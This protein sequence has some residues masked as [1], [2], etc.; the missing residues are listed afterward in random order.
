MLLWY[1]MAA[2]DFQHLYCVCPSVLQANDVWASSSQFSASSG[3]RGMETG[4]VSFRHQQC[5]CTPFIFLTSMP[6][7]LRW[8][9]LQR[10]VSGAIWRVPIKIAS[11]CWS[12]HEQVFVT[13]LLQWPWHWPDD[14]HIRTWAVSHW[15]IPDVWKW[16]SCIK[17]F[18]SC[19]LTYT[20]TDR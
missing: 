7:N 1:L 15:D 18:E 13:F 20:H 2:V 12:M 16:T 6:S 3:S 9:H 14:L 10:I 8:D 17:A 4:N 11:W 5:V 19:R